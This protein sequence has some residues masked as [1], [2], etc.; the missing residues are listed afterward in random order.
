MRPL[1]R[2]LVYSRSAE[3]REHF[4]EHARS[5]YGFPVEAVDSAEAL[6]ERSDI[7]TAA[8]SALS[9][10]FDGSLIRPGTHVNPLS[11]WQIDETTVRRSA[12]FTTTKGR[13]Y[14][15]LFHGEKRD[16]KAT[17]PYWKEWDRVQELE[18][19]M[20]GEMIGRRSPDEITLF[21]GDGAGLQFVTLGHHVL[22]KARERG[23]GRE[24][25]TDWFLGT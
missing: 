1:K 2:V 3:N 16:Y 11:A 24:L 13:V 6:V 17:S 9:P 19:V 10:T 18:R 7:I 15:Y 8:T 20:T 5:Q 22:T 4:A 14:E 12:L 25:P 23:I 21:Y